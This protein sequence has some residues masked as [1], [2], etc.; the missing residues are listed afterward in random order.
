MRGERG[1]L[2]TT[3]YPRLRGNKAHRGN[4]PRNFLPDRRLGKS[5]PELPIS[6]RPGGVLGLVGKDHKRIFR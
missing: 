6:R 2:K 3:N 1:H 4:V 5:F